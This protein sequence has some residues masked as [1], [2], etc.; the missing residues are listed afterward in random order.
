MKKNTSLYCGNCGEPGHI[1]K[2]C[3]TTDYEYGNNSVS[4]EPRNKTTR[5]SHGKKTKYNRIC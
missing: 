1:Y 3:F 2:K 5:I 4:K